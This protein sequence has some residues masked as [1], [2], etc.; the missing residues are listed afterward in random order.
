MTLPAWFYHTDI[1]THNPEA[2]RR[3]AILSLRPDEPVPPG[4][5]RISV[6][7]HPWDTAENQDFEALLSEIEKRAEEE[8]IV[9]IGECGLDKVR[10][11][12]MD[13]QET[14]FRRQLE[15]AERHRLPVIIH[16][17]RAYDRLLHLHKLL[18]PTVP[19]IIHGFRGNPTLAAQLTRAG[20]HL[21]APAPSPY[22]LHETD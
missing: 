11:A 18:R 10:G 15:M 21:S 4:C 8:K 19:W 2:A 3:G 1:H 16:C 13:T 20:I 17:V 14:L 9:A 6:G 22:P 7:I 5:E 12:D